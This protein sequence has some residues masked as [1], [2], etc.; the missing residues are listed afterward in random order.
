M[1]I[2]LRVQCGVHGKRVDSWNRLRLQHRDI[3]MQPSI[4][5]H[6]H[7]HHDVMVCIAININDS[8]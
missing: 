8:V 3:T 2:S 1:I 4:Y 5:V 6:I 7:V